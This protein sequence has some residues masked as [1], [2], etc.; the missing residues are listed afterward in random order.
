MCPLCP[1]D[2]I[3]AKSVAEYVSKQ[4]NQKGEWK[5]KSGCP[6]KQLT[7]N[8][9]TVTVDCKCYKPTDRKNQYTC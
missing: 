6:E 1:S 4:L 2:E 5:S 7:A 8:Y 3:D 9:K